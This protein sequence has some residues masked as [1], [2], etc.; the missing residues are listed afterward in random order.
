M[1]EY[2]SCPNYMGEIIEW[3]GFALSTQN[4]AAILFAFNTLAII[5]SRAL[6]SHKWYKKNFKN[7]PEDRKALIPYLI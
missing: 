2:V 5:G 7:Y 4:F 1:F 6:E 3:F